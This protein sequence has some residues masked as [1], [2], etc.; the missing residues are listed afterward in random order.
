MKVNHR[1]GALFLQKNRAIAHR[2]QSPD[3]FKDLQV[4]SCCISNR[5]SE[6][7]IPMRISLVKAE[8]NILT[9]LHRENG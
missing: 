3:L 4:R 1:S 6:E 8:N 7:R 2:G 5:H 9:A